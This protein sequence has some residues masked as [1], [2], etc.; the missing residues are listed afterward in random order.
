MSPSIDLRQGLVLSAPVRAGAGPLRSGADVS[1]LPRCRSGDNQGSNG[2]CAVFSMASWAEIVHGTPISDA[3]CLAVY[4]AALKRLNLSAGSGLTFGD[5]FTAAYEA[6]WLPGAQGC[7]MVFDLARLPEQPLLAGYAV[8]EAWAK[9]NAAGC[10]DHAAG[11]DILG[12]HAVVIVAHGLLGAA[13]NATGPWVY[14]ENS[15]GRDWGW[16]GIAM[17]SEPLHRQMIRELWAIV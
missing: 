8:T 14:V 11:P 5:A 9:P 16:N 7:E 13:P 17:M 10:L 15:W 4:N 6:G 1:W 12:Y 3:A 2:A